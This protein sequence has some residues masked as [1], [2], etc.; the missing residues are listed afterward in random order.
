M[1]SSLSTVSPESPLEIAS[2]RLPAIS[3]SPP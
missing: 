1:F 3:S 2:A